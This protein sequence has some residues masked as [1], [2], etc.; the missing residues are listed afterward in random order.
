VVLLRLCPRCPA[1]LPS[2]GRGPCPNCK[3]AENGRRGKTARDRGYDAEH[4]RLSK[5]A[6]ATHP[7][8]MDCRATEDL[9]G[10]HI[11]PRSQGGLNELSNY[12]VRCRSCNSARGNRESVFLGGATRDPEPTRPVSQETRRRVMASYDRRGSRASEGRLARPRQHLF[13]T[14][15]MRAKGAG[16]RASPASTSGKPSPAPTRGSS[17]KSRRP[18]HPLEACTPRRCCRRLRDD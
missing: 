12:A 18:R 8:C 9:V 1:L 6:I 4:K 14:S 15:Q 10:D 16:P 11:I 2:P 13:G 7:Y 3:R 5:L 17:S